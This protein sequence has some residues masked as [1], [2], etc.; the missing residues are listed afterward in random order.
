M[1]PKP[2]RSRSRSTSTF[3]SSSRYLSSCIQDSFWFNAFKTRR[4]LLRPLKVNIQLS[5]QDINNQWKESLSFIISSLKCMRYRLSVSFNELLKWRCLRIKFT[6][7]PWY[8][9]L[10]R[11]FILRLRRSWKQRRQFRFADMLRW[12][13][14]QRWKKLW[15]Q[16][17]LSWLRSKRSW[18]CPFTRKFKLQYMFP[19]K[20][21]WPFQSMFTE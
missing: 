9:K 17:K 10:R 19:Q 2:F 8:A 6:R 11:Q 12:R 7:Y 13:R 21:Q 15:R 14:L 3:Q 1:S 20:N 4:L 5:C 16:R 18:R